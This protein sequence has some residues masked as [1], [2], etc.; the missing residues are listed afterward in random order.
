[1]IFN[2]YMIVSYTVC[3][4]AILDPPNIQLGE[5]A[6]G[7]PTSQHTRSESELYASA[8][9]HIDR[10]ESEQYHATPSN[11]NYPE[12]EME[13]EN[14]PRV[15]IWLKEDNPR[16]DHFGHVAVDV[17][18]PGKFSQSFRVLVSILSTGSISRSVWDNKILDLLSGI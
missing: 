12:S 9:S 3:I 14:K 17:P 11:V 1:M 13:D 10:P 6:G 2:R 7:V 5:D 4:P 16:W 8:A 18:V 15:Y